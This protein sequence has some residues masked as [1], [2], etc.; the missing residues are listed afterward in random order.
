MKE[1]YSGI[2]IIKFLFSVCVVG[3]HTNILTS[4][5]SNIEWGIFHGIFRLAVPFF[6]VCSGFFLGLKLYRTNTFNDGKNEIKKYI[7]RLIVPYIFWLII[8]LPFQVYKLRADNF[9]LIIF[10]L[11]RSILF[12]PWGALWYIWALIIAI[13]LITPFYKKGKIKYAM[14]IGGILYF[15]ALICNNYYFLIENTFLQKFIDIYLKVFH[16]SRNGLFV[17]LY[18]V[19][20]G[21]Y[22]AELINKGINIY[23]WKHKVILIVSYIFLIIEIFVIKRKTYRDDNSL[24]L[25]F[26]IVIPELLIF[27]MRYRVKIKTTLLRNY[28]TGIYFLHI[29]I[30]DLTK[31]ILSLQGINVNNYLMFIIVLFLSFGI[32]T[33]LYKVENKYINKVIR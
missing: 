3:I 2:D 30:R 12:Y 28:S 9:V 32:L 33:I 22:I 11:I 20:T 13:L 31:S 26:I 8:G 14:L 25:M 15:F 27:L 4:E 5:T 23:N 7:K 21:L 16:S 1:S 19:S 29:P 24:Y 10:K 6:F 18:F 17:G